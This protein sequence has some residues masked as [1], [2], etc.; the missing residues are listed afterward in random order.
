M[1]PLQ[2]AEIAA[3][4]QKYGHA[5]YKRCLRLIGNK[6]DARELMQEC[7]CQFYAGRERFKGESSP[8]TF[9]YRIATNLSI[10][11]LRRRT[12]AGV[13]VDLDDA[14]ALESGGRSQAQQ[15]QAIQELAMLTEGMDDET[16][17]IAVMS[18]VDGMTQD[19][20]AEALDLSRKTIGKKL[21]RFTD[22]AQSRAG[23]KA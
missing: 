14:P 6:E 18:H 11:R 13:K 7:F 5:L 23:V 8:F 9:L 1:P 2:E 22:V 3:L 15:L 20:I 17:T 21:Q 19:E 4:Y 12:T 16:L 10:D